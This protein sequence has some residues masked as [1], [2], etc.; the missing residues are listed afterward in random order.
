MIAIL[1]E[2][3]WEYSMSNT[4]NEIIKIIEKELEQNE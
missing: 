3:G 4:V 2:A 1:T